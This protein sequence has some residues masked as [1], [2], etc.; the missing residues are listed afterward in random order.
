MKN[1]FFSNTQQGR[2][3]TKEVEGT[4]DKKNSIRLTIFKIQVGN[5]LMSYVAANTT[6]P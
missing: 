1:F 2:L 4:K 5:L 6:F 3:D